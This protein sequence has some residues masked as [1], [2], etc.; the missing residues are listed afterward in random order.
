[1]SAV[2]IPIALPSTESTLDA[3]KGGLEVFKGSFG[4]AWTKVQQAFT[5]RTVLPPPG[6]FEG[7]HREARRTYRNELFKKN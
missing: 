7:L 4:Q 3:L 1:M 5:D 2:N 6:T